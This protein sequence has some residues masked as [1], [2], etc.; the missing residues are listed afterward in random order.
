MSTT[1]V[2]EKIM[3]K[4]AKEN[5]YVSKNYDETFWRDKD[6]KKYPNRHQG[7]KECERR[8]KQMSK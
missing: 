3:E 2:Q 5:G 1:E 7:K 4:N 6:N 8:I